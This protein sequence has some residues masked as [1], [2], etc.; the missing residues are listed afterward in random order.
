[1]GTD[2]DISHA[3]RPVYLGELLEIDEAQ[4]C[5]EVAHEQTHGS[6]E[7]VFEVSESLVQLLCLPDRLLQA[8]ESGGRIVDGCSAS[9]DRFLNLPM[10]DLLDLLA[11]SATGRI[12][13]LALSLTLSF[14]AGKT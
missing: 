8:F 2:F 12:G 7:L 11:S 1:M 9:T 14:F 5:T 13:E 3:G 6:V 10:P 4:I